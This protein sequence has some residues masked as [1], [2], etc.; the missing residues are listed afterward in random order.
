MTEAKEP[1]VEDRF[2][3]LVAWMKGCCGEKVAEKEGAVALVAQSKPAVSYEALG[4]EDI[5]DTRFQSWNFGG[6]MLHVWG[7]VAYY[8]KV[9]KMFCH[10]IVEEVVLTVAF[11][12]GTTEEN[13]YCGVRSRGEQVVV[14]AAAAAAGVGEEAMLPGHREIHRCC[15]LMMLVVMAIRIQ[16]VNRPEDE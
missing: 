11:A 14:V 6:G 2:W 3:T 4:S 5:G 16:V 13:W 12:A 10:R 15:L 8:L 9:V 1:S 7:E